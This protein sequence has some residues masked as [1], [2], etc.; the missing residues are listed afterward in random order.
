[1]GLGIERA[2]IMRERFQQWRN[3]LKIHQGWVMGAGKLPWI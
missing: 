1:M 3:K 2:P